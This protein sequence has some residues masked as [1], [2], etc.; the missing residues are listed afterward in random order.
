M[1]RILT[2][3]AL[4]LA[5]L[6]LSACASIPTGPSVLVLPGDGKNFDQFRIDDTVCRQHAY[7]QAGGGQQAAQE[8]AVTSAA[9]G[10]GVGAAAG[11]AIGSASGNFGS[12]AAIG[13]GVGLLLG[14]AYGVDASSRSYYAAQ[15]RYDNA[16]MQC[17]YAKG[18]QI[19]GARRTTRSTDSAPIGQPP[20]A[21]YPPP[22]P[23]Y[24]APPPGNP[25]PTPYN[26]RR[27]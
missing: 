6:A 26:D 11:A 16:Y 12:G 23:G 21:N 14:S 17:M 20:A 9:V 4:L 24:A 13:A 1:N 7:E 8:S 3:I 5:V 18:N 10:T 19:P 2:C 22:P 25:S 27:Y 15:R